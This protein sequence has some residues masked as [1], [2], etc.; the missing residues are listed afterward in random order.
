MPSNLPPAGRS[1]GRPLSAVCVPRG[2]ASPARMEDA[3]S[4]FGYTAPIQSGP[5]KRSPNVVSAVT[6]PRCADR[7]ENLHPRVRQSNTPPEAFESI[8]PD[9]RKK[10]NVQKVKNAQQNARRMKS[11]DSYTSEKFDGQWR[12]PYRTEREHRLNRTAAV[13]R[14]LASFAT[15]WHSPI[16]ETQMEPANKGTVKSIL[17]SS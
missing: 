14:D 8:K 16:L 6:T 13:R 3:S 12:R 4:R 15:I 10:T 11:T 2:Q 9:V 1:V 7:R 5:P 17:R